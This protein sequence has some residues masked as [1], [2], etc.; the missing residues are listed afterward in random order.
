[1]RIGVTGSS[2]KLGRPTAELLRGQGHDV[3]GLDRSG[4]AGFG[5]TQVD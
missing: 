5:F 1:M 3:L 2:G 4:P